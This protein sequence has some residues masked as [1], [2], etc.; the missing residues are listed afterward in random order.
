M[1]GDDPLPLD[2][3]DLQLRGLRAATGRVRV[4]AFDGERGFPA[5][6]VQALRMVETAVTGS[7]MDLRITGLRTDALAIVAVHD[8]EGLGFEAADW[9][10]RPYGGQA[11]AGADAR[12]L[13]DLCFERIVQRFDLGGAPV[14]L[15]FRY[16]RGPAGQSSLDLP[17]W[18]TAAWRLVF[19]AA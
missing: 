18:V 1:T 14:D 5:D 17:R 19:G 13:D 16:A 7:D 15:R 2:G 4:L 11:A 12:D 10:G 6:P 8:A 3:L 9:L